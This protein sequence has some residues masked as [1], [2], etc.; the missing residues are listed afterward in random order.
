MIILIILFSLNTQQEAFS[1]TEGA[2][3]ARLGCQ[4]S[5]GWVIPVYTTAQ[6]L[7]KHEPKLSCVRGTSTWECQHPALLLA[8]MSRNALCH[9]PTAREGGSMK[10]SPKFRNHHPK[11]VSGTIHHGESSSMWNGVVWRIVQTG[12]CTARWCLESQE[13]ITCYFRRG[14][15]FPGSY[16]DSATKLNLK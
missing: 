1:V 6:C 2:D 13:Y 15:A 3:F 12:I 4:W 8:P 14:G 5:E 7:F 9:I 11:A 10:P 16:N